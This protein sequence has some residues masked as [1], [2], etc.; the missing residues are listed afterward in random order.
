M[1]NVQNAIIGGPPIS[2]NPA[3][4]PNDK[5]GVE[6]RDGGDVP[7]VTGRFTILETSPSALRILSFLVC[8]IDES[9]LSNSDKSVHGKVFTVCYPMARDVRTSVSGARAHQPL[10]HHGKLPRPS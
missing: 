9:K 10:I 4:Q 6:V 2:S 8:L 5:G 7:G 1:C 3:G